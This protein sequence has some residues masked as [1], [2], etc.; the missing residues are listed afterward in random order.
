MIPNLIDDTLVNLQEE[1]DKTQIQEVL[2]ELDQE[3]IGL[4]PVKTRI[5]EIAALLL[6]EKI[7]KN[8]NYIN[9]KSI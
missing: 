5:K 4:V 2:D 1:Y 9:E 6:I 3:L 8:L 7:K